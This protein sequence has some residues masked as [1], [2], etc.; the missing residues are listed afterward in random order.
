MS[1]RIHKQRTWK[2][3]RAGALSALALLFAQQASAQEA[4]APADAA[5][6][7]GTDIVVTANRRAERLQDVP[8]AVNVLSNET[9]RTASIADSQFL[10]TLVPG[11]SITQINSS[12]YYL[13]GV[14]FA[15]TAVNAEQSVASYIDGV[16]VFTTIGSVSLANLERVEV[17]RGPQG[18]LFGRNTTGG[19]IQAVTRDP[20]AKPSLEASLGYGNYKT[21]SGTF[22]GNA[23]VTE[24]LGIS[25]S[26]DFRNQ[27]NGFGRNTT[28]GRDSFKRSDTEVRVKVAYEPSEDTR[29]TGFFQ[30][31]NV[32]GSGINYIPLKGT[33]GVDGVDGAAYGRFGNR[34]NSDNDL[35]TDSYLG[36]IRLEQGLGDFATLTSIS[37]YQEVQPFAKF[38][39]DATP[40]NVFAATQDLF[41]HNV[42]QEFQLSSK[43]EGPFTWIVGAYYYN[44]LAGFSPMVLTGTGGG[45]PTGQTRFIRRQRTESLAGFGQLTYK[46]TEATKLTAGMRYTDESQ[47]LPRDLVTLVGPDPNPVRLPF[48]SVP[49][50]TLDSSG[51]TWRVALDHQFSD[52]FMGY[53]SWNRGLKSG[54]FTLT[55]AADVPPYRPE[56]L[57]SYEAGLKMEFLNGRVR[58]NPALF[59]YKFKNIQ[60]NSFN[61]FLT[62]LTNAASATIKGLD[63]DA[64]VKVSGGLQ[65]TATFEYLDSQYDEFPTSIG[66]VP[67][68]APGGGARQV[69]NVN[70]KGNRLPYAPKTSGSF[71]AS[72]TVPVAGGELLLDGS[73]RFV[74]NQFSSSS[75]FFK[76]PSYSLVSAGVSWT[77]SDERFSIR[78]WGDNI[79][80]KDYAFQIFDS[81]LGI[82]RNP[83]APRTYG[84]TLSTKL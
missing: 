10:A 53:V 22:Y 9:L 59:V 3:G 18:T 54:G 8:M 19:I 28:T 63:L 78:V 16:F 41:F 27:G 77:T 11:L 61:G 24:N 20:L 32:K 45:G 1:H 73:F 62:A 49:A 81:G 37:S 5:E 70:A 47:K 52:D 72:Y 46:L 55:T 34:A 48:P 56:K 44:A 60:V 14:G 66:F 6:S 71:G 80:D 23:H 13:R 26:G 43:A 31:R 33:R 68:A 65:L 69:N 12:Q 50:A 58:I 82:F 35:K 2:L 39:S 83:G 79:F 25:L 21:L 67:V 38:D 36:Y 30:Y 42:S 74:G 51:W 7:E 4:S 15:G 75:N 76:V 29:V 64:A 57:D 84:V 40:L 17:L